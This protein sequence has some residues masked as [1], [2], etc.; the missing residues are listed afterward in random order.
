MT[1]PL[2]ERILRTLVFRRCEILI[3]D[4]VLEANLNQLEMTD[5]DV[6]L[7]MD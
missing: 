1:T 4:M 5:F 3:E 2:G 7:G 6:I